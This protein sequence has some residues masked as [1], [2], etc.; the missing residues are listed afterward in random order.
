[1]FFKLNAYAFKCASV[2]QFSIIVCSYK[3]KNYEVHFGN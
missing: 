1:M 2:N 3:K